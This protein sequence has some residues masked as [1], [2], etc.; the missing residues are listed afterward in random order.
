MHIRMDLI[1]SEQEGLCLLIVIYSRFM[2]QKY[3]KNVAD[4]S[5]VIVI[6]GTGRYTYFMKNIG[7]N[8]EKGEGYD[9][10]ENF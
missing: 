3:G 10:G 5:T 7:I 8:K 1:W 4:K 6:S 2:L 9:S